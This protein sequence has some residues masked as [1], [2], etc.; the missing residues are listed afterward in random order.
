MICL[1]L[2][3]FLLNM[4][5][6]PAIFYKQSMLFLPLQSHVSSSVSPP[7][8]HRSSPVSSQSTPSC[9]QNT[10]QNQWPVGVALWILHDHLVTNLLRNRENGSGGVRKKRSMIL[11][12]IK[13]LGDN[14]VKSTSWAVK[15]HHVSCWY[16]W[17]LW[18]CQKNS[19]KHAVIYIHDAIGTHQMK[20]IKNN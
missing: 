4:G 15:E 8:S 10:H 5:D 6:V 7:V 3:I 11:E 14:M 12:E 1:H 19:A 20:W 13:F 2:N 17:K 18:A 16:E 9:I